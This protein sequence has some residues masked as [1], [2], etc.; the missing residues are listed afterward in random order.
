M[1]RHTLFGL[2]GPCSEGYGQACSGELHPPGTRVAK[3]WGSFIMRGSC[4]WSM[5]GSRQGGQWADTS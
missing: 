4:R 3:K 2:V 5:W 1:C